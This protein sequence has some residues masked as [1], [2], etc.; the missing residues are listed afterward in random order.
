MLKSHGFRPLHRYAHQPFAQETGDGPSLIKP[1]AG[2]DTS[3]SGP[4]SRFNEIAMRQNS[5][6]VPGYRRDYLVGLIVITTMSMTILRRLQ[7]KTR[8]GTVGPHVR[9]NSGPDSDLTCGRATCGRAPFTARY[10]AR[11]SI[12]PERDSPRARAHAGRSFAG[13][14]LESNSSD[15]RLR[16]SGGVS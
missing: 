16:T 15:S 3:S 2:R 5:V 11:A 4:K 14:W 1:L 9:S 6:V 10:F 12:A 13:K 7:S 8:T